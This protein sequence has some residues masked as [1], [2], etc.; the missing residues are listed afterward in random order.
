MQLFNIFIVIQ[1]QS[2]EFFLGKKVTH[3]VTDKPIDRDGNLLNVN[4][5]Y[6]SSTSLLIQ[7]AKTPSPAQKSTASLH[8]FN[9]LNN[10]DE[11]AAC[12]RP[13]SRA[14]A[15]VQ[16][17]RT[18]TQ[19]VSPIENKSVQCASTQS[20]SPNPMQLALNWGTPIWNTE[21]TLKFLEKVTFALK[22]ENQ[23]PRT[24]SS[25]KSSTNHH[26]N[27]HKTANVKQLNGEYIKI[28]SI[29]KVRL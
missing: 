14:D 28:E 24:T 27:H 19:P 20:F 17:A 4:N 23:Q 6:L 15:M 12:S 26:H 16:R 1:F 3:F 10:S 2:I 7:P 18:T 22:L 5:H 25:T 9:D 11:R 13:K 29:Q 21:Y 8:T